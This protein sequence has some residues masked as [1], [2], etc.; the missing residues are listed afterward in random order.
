M[1]AQLFAILLQ[2]IPQRDQYLS[3]LLTFHFR[4]QLQSSHIPMQ[5]LSLCKLSFQLSQNNQQFL[6]G[7]TTHPVL[8]LLSAGPTHCDLLQTTGGNANPNKFLIQG[9]EGSWQSE[10]QM[11]NYQLVY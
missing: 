4:R 7:P 9:F 10:T 6:P 3:Q 11:L 1:N 8:E 5:I 2:V